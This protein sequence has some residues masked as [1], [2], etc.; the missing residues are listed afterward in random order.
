MPGHC[1]AQ[2]VRFLAR[3]QPHVVP[4]RI[5]PVDFRGPEKHDA[6][7]I[8]DHEALGRFCASGVGGR[9]ATP[10]AEAAHRRG[11]AAHPSCASAALSWHDRVPPETF[12]IERL[13]QVVERVHLEG[14]QRVLVVG[15][16]EDDRAARHPA[17]TASS[18]S[19]PSSSGI[20]TSRKT[21]SGSVLRGSPRPPPRRRPHSATTSMSGSRASSSRNAARAR[22]ARRPRSA[23]RIGSALDST[24]AAMPRRAA[25]PS[26]R[27]AARCRASSSK[28][29]RVAV[30]A[31]AA[32]PACCAR[33]IPP[34][35]EAPAVRQTRAVVA[36][37]RGSAVR[38][39]AR[40][41]RRCGP[42]PRAARCRAGSRSRPAAAGADSAP[43]IEQ[44]RRARSP[45]RTVRRSRKRICSI[46]R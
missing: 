36:R 21:R 23:T 14:A 35:L 28:R 40:R 29:W 20:C 33:P 2:Q 25:R 16:D 19:K 34:C 8:L 5:D 18:T 30:D 41:A 45:C 43:R 11:P 27:A 7:R 38:R 46:S 22:A 44:R 15:G 17:P 10:A 39:C 42:P 1:L 26:R 9:R 12:A 32:G 6:A 4:S 37:P 24:C 13:E 3:V 31:A